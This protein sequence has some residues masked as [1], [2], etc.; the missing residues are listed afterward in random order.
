MKDV[1]RFVEAGDLPEREESPL[2]TDEMI[3]E[4][5]FLDTPDIDVARSLVED[6]WE[7]PIERIERSREIRNA[8]EY[9]ERTGKPVAAP[10]PGF[11]G[12]EIPESLVG[13]L[14]WIPR[15][16]VENVYRYTMF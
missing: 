13:Y 12:Q 2:D 16:T 5:L 9:V 10:A 6:Y 4:L 14:L 11:V 7:W 8:R 3:V 15:A 1:P